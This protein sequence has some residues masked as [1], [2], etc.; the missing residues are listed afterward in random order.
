M[1]S[2]IYPPIRTF[3]ARHGRLS[4]SRL[5]HLENVVP[6][7]D[8]TS[9]ASPVNLREIFPGRK[10]VVD[11]G[12]GMGHHTEA[13]AAQGYGVLAIDVHTPGICR[14]AEFV[15]D[16][17]IENVRVH[18]GD[19]IPVLAEMLEAG[20]V[21]ELHVMFPDPWPKA[22]HN[23]RRVIQHSLLAL[24]DR[25]LTSDGTITMVT[26]DDDYAEHIRLVLSES[27]LFEIASE[28]A[29]IPS[30]RYKRRADHMK[31]TIH[32]FIAQRK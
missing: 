22:R 26:D 11:F 7:L 19:G 24:A 15:S 1:Q 10:I 31:N 30:T 14:I 4:A 3:H 18:L 16:N 13:L 27:T 9:L 2:P 17:N 12:C 5:N 29:D 21:D 8:I 6:T 28:E 32:G 25:V 20:S 23:K